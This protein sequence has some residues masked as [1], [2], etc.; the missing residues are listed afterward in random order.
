M[1]IPEPYPQSVHCRDVAMLLREPERRVRRILNKNRRFIAW[2]EKRR[3]RPQSA[4]CLARHAAGISIPR[5]EQF[6]ELGETDVRSR[7]I[8]CFHYGDF[9]YGMNRLMCLEAPQRQRLL[10]CQRRS[11]A[12]YF[13]NMRRAFGERTAG[14]EDEILVH[15]TSPTQLAARLRR[16]GTSL[17]TF[18]D[19]PL[20]M[21]AR[22]GV[23]L[24]LR[25]AS[26]SRGAA[27]LAVA[28]SVPLLPVIC[29][30]SQGFTRVLIGRQLEPVPRLGESRSQLI[31]RLSQSLALILEQRVQEA[32]EYWRYISLLPHYFASAKAGDVGEPAVGSPGNAANWLPLQP[33]QRQGAQR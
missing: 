1:P 2:L 16:G 29:S 14:P 23:R 31:V 22:V 4:A 26:L 10:L 33:R 27:T 25:R 7:I 6:R 11:S 8:V 9:V 15:E 19:L 28:A 18:C 30:R 24:L 20:G 21:G 32:P 13:H 3:N 17:L 5:A 12:A